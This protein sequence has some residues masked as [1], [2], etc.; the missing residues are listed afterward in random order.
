MIREHLAQAPYIGWLFILLVIAGVVLAVAVLLSDTPAV[1]V[2]TAVTM[3]LT[4]AAFL[5]SRT[6][7]LPE[8]G[9]DVGNWTQPL[10]Y[11]SVLAE[12]LGLGLSLAVLQHSRP[13]TWTS[14]SN[15]S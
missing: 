10:G 12:V 3:A 6:V 5:L 8:I 13:R 2:A 9:D 4:L 7:G 14:T 1:Y 11:P 15:P